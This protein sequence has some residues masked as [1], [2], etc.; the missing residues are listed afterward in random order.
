MPLNSITCRG[1][2]TNP[3]NKNPS[4]SNTPQP[5]KL[6]TLPNIF[7]FIPVQIELPPRRSA[8]SSPCLAGTC[9]RPWKE[10]N[11]DQKVSGPAGGMTCSKIFASFGREKA[12]ESIVR[13]T[14]SSHDIVSPEMGQS[15]TQID[16]EMEVI[17]APQ[18]R[19]HMDTPCHH[20]THP[21]TP[22]HITTSTWR[23][24]T[25]LLHSTFEEESQ[26]W[27]ALQWVTAQ[28]TT[29][30]EARAIGH[31]NSL[32]EAK[33]CPIMSKPT[34]HEAIISVVKV[35]VTYSFSTSWHGCQRDDVQLWQF[36]HYYVVL[37]CTHVLA[38]Y[39]TMCTSPD[40]ELI[41]TVQ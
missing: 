41:G 6:H 1:N 4:K 24:W 28:S 15:A 21:Y 35:K 7:T 16:C 34:W 39:Q 19:I 20:H 2:S 17:W 22:P 9:Q 13:P 23:V 26:P 36:W 14:I 29:S 12:K 5:V 18:F 38:G 10:V 25:L 8:Q 3:T 37:A 11:E 31:S 33:I 27:I 32:L 30:C 40:F